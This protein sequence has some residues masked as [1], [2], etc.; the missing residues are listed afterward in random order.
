VFNTGRRPSRGGGK[1]RKF[2][3]T[4][5]TSP[6]TKERNYSGKRL[7]EGKSEKNISLDVRDYVLFQKRDKREKTRLLKPSVSERS[8]TIKV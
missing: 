6:E 4:G 7:Q 2:L 1:E 3:P 5:T 8:A